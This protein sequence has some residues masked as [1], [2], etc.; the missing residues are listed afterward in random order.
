VKILMMSTDREDFD[1]EYRSW[2]LWWRLQIIKIV[3]SVI[4]K[5]F[6]EDCRPSVVHKE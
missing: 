4:Y 3:M 5:E 6:D 2:R 1:D